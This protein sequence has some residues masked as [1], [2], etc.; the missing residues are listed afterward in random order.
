MI[1]ITR[2]VIDYHALTEAVR[3]PLAGAVLLFLG[4]VREITG[5]RRTT[6]LEYDAYEPMALREMEQ[7]ATETRQRWTVI[8]V[9]IVH[10]LGVLELGDVSVAVA[11]SCPHRDQAYAAGRFLIDTLKERVPIWKKE[12]WADGGTEW[13]HP[14]GSEAGR[15]GE[16]QN[17][18]TSAEENAA[19]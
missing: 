3:S 9:A 15:P 6:R 14:A 10:R 4:T 11:V 12:N 8:D 18:S 16:V 7:L 1:A 5:E 17:Q 2:E 19:E 13:V